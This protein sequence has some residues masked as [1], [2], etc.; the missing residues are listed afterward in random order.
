MLSHCQTKMYVL[1]RIYIQYCL[2]CYIYALEEIQYV[3]ATILPP[4]QLPT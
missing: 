1:I 2:R 4:I 3:I